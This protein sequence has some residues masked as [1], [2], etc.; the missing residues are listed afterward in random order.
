MGCYG[1]A[2]E[3]RVTPLQV[4]QVVPSERRVVVQGSSS[5]ASWQV[6]YWG[7]GGGAGA[8]QLV[9]PGSQGIALSPELPV[10]TQRWP[11]PQSLLLSQRL[12]GMG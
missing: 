11:L 8:P 7:S 4:V 1:V 9:A 6:P 12:G 2:L 5:P 3:Q 10:L